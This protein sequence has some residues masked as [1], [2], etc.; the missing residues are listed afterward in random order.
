MLERAWAKTARFRD[1]DETRDAKFPYF[2]RLDVGKWR[3]WK[4]YPGALLLMPLRLLIIVTDVIVL[5][6]LIKLLTC[7][8]DFD[9]G[10]LKGCRK[11]VIEI[12][13]KGACGL[14]MI[15]A[16]IKAEQVH[17]EVDYSFYL[18]PA[19]KEESKRAKHLSTIVT[20]HISWVDPVILTYC[21]A[22]AYAPSAEFKHTP[23]VNTMCDV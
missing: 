22:P 5:C 19:Y 4:F 13:L 14:F 23:L 15:V 20:N 12:L 21:V 10:S 3:R 17:H 16:G 1:G 6:L 2:R 11:W 9:K 18:G 8:H 7:G